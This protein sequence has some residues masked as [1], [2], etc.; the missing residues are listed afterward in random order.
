MDSNTKLLNNKINKLFKIIVNKIKSTNILKNNPFSFI[1]IISLLIGLLIFIFNVIMSY[2][3]KYFKFNSN[4]KILELKNN[5]PFLAYIKKDNNVSFINF[6]KQYLSRYYNKY[7]EGIDS[8]ILNI[9]DSKTLN[10]ISPN[11]DTYNFWIYLSSNNSG[12]TKYFMNSSYNNNR[13]SNYNVGNLFNTLNSDYKKL[14]FSRSDGKYEYPSLYLKKNKLHLYVK[15][16]ENDSETDYDIAEDTNISLNLDVWTNITVSLNYNIISIYKNGKLEKTYTIQTKNKALKNN[17]NF[18]LFLLNNNKL[19]DSVILNY[20]DINGTFVKPY[21]LSSCLENSKCLS[22]DNKLYKYKYYL[23]NNNKYFILNDIE[24]KNKNCLNDK[25]CND[26]IQT[27]E[28]ELSLI[29]KEIIEYDFYGFEGY[30]NEFKYY[31]NLFKPGDIYKIYKRDLDHIIKPFNKY[32]NKYLTNNNLELKLEMNKINEK[33]K[34]KS[35][36]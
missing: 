1:L 18:A 3:T 7:I 17:N 16:L 29:N 36:E 23:I 34:K 2:I 27:N 12:L 22:D 6:Y 35:N 15:I 20:K 5:M 10:S 24:C 21:D 19:D 31:N 13:I 30:L 9:I 33:I 26:Y 32:V 4:I 25:D 8:N 11:R 14:I 28:M